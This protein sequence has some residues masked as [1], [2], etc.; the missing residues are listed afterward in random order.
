MLPL[1]LQLAKFP[2][3]FLFA[4]VRLLHM[5]HITRKCYLLVALCL[6]FIVSCDSFLY[7]PI[8]SFSFSKH[9]GC[10]HAMR[11]L[12]TA[13]DFNECENKGN[14]TKYNILTS[15]KSVLGGSGWNGKYNISKKSLAKLGMNVLL[16]YGFVSNVSY[17]TCVILAW[18]GHGK[19]YKLS[20]LAPGQWKYFL[21]IY[22][23]FF[24]ANNV[25]R[26]LRFSLSLVLSPV[27]DNM[28]EVLEKRLHLRKATATG[29]LV[30]L[31]NVLGSTTYLLLG[32]TLA[33]QWVGVPL[34]P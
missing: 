31:V 26:P 16:A 19:A 33:T 30:F 34:L 4:T 20:P 15:L 5:N 10:G 23:G 2:Q 25:L 11:E 21:L 29:L 1:S 12:N 9:S 24:A 17:I 8:R 7:K 22:S 32:L 13:R 6:M 27:F 14:K 18:I 3:H 28:V